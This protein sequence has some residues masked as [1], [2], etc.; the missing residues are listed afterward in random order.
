MQLEYDGAKNQF[1]I[2]TTDLNNLAKLTID[3]IHFEDNME[4]A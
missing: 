2:E 1:I 3:E 4:L